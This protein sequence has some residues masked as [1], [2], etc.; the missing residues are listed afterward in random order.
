MLG[1]LLFLKYY[2]DEGREQKTIVE[3]ES[4][5]EDCAYFKRTCYRTSAS[6]EELEPIPLNRLILIPFTGSSYFEIGEFKVGDSVELYL[7]TGGIFHSASLG[8]FII[9]PIDFVH[10]LQNLIN[11]YRD[12]D[13]SE[14]LKYAVLDWWKNSQK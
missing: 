5:R 4:I 13:T 12:K 8:E 3:V 14:K 2:D 1:N 11:V 7:G 6:P 9:Y 10:Q